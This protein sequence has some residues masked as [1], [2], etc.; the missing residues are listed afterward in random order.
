M[1]GLFST[2]RKVLFILTSAEDATWNEKTGYWLEEVAEPYY[3][4]LKAGFTVEIASIAGGKPPCDPTSQGDEWQTD[5]T[6]KFESDPKVQEMMESTT[7]LSEIED[8]V[9]YECL[10]IPGGHGTC[11]DI[12]KSEILAALLPRFLSSGGI[13]SAVCH[14]PLGLTKAIKADGSPLV[15]GVKVTGFSNSEEKAVGKDRKVPFLL[16]SKLKELG[17]EYS[18]GPNWEPYVVA[19]EQIVTGQNPKSSL[20]TAQKTIAILN[21]DKKSVFCG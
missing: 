11:F 9:S 21:I 13:I 18:C 16:E 15:K 2:P 3:A 17:A 20:L 5:N 1:G 10:F 4:F 8:I 19:E 12:A 14:G 6:R 7:K